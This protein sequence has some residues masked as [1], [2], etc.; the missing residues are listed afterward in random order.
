[1]IRHSP[2]RRRGAPRIAGTLDI[3]SSKIACVIAE[4]PSDN[5]LE[6]L[7]VL[8]TGLHRS[9]G[10]L[11]GTITDPRAAEAAIR[12]A[13][14]QAERAAGL[15]LKDVFV[16]ITCGRLKS[17]SFAA[18]AEIGPL[19]VRD[20]DLTRVIDGA[21]SYVE[22]DGRALVH[23]N[24][25]HYRLDGSPCGEDPRGMAAGRLTAGMHAVAAGEGA[26]RNLIHTVERCD[27]TVSG[28]VAAPYAAALAVTSAEERRLGVTVVDM[29]GGT[30]TLAVFNEGHFVHCEA[31]PAGGHHL[32]FEIAQK[33]HAPIA[34]AE[35]IKTLYASM[36]NAQ[37]DV[38]DSFRYAILGD[39][40][41]GLGHGTR[42][43]LAEVVRPRVE[44]QLCEVAARL[45]ASGWTGGPVVL[46]GGASQLSGLAGFAASYLRRD[47][48]TSGPQSRLRLP[49]LAASPA[50]AAAVGL[51]L[52]GPGGERHGRERLDGSRESYLGRVSRWVSSV[53]G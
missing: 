42:A 9:Q 31:F 12:A 41:N 2:P 40:E 33:L 11:G 45:D 1:M 32:T 3:G 51:A 53:V 5:N 27:L 15:T 22:R 6:S 28:L 37:S 18:H 29:G 39:A 13:V 36:V 50:L 23:M 24:R 20:S 17:S 30:I 19:G 44:S 52:A 38:C 7:R 43:Q 49:A 4:V 47:V 46:T 26:I 16:S 10:V 48:T 8:G 25:L 34:E 35:R 21:R 14:A